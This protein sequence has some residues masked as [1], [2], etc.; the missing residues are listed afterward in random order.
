MYEFFSLNVKLLLGMRIY[1]C[2]LNK[3]KMNEKHFNKHFFKFKFFFSP[4]R[5]EYKMIKQL[6]VTYYTK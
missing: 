6:C 4:S 3:I 1:E 5:C 2:F